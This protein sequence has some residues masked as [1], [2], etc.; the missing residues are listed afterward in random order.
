MVHVLYSDRVP[1]VLEVVAIPHYAWD[2]ALASDLIVDD[3]LSIVLH[4]LV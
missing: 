3:D 4:F 1:L 2:V